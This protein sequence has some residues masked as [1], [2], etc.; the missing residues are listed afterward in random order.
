MKLWFT[1]VRQARWG[2]V[3]RLVTV[4][5]HGDFTVLPQA[6]NTITYYPIQSFYPD[7]EPARPC[8]ILI[9]LRARLDRDKYQF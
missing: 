9:M 6:T 3:Y 4:R 1:V 8:P 7:T 5:T 2:N